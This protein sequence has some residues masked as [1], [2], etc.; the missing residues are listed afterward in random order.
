MKQVSIRTPLGIA[1]ITG[2]ENG[3]QEIKVDDSTDESS[4]TPE[5]LQTA[6]LQ[7]QEYFSGR[8]QQ[9]DLKLNPKGTDFQK[10][11]WEELR[12]IPYGTTI[13]YLELSRK[14]GDEK[15]IRAVASA[16]GKNPLWI[17]VPCH[18]VIGSDGSLTGYAGGL[19]RKK[20]LLDLENPPLQQSLF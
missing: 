5:I 7:L 6:I 10:K 2:D 8:R 3:V 16:N 9:F 12:N 11:V 4:E 19:H 17:V 13:S 15:A 14:L 18:R 1:T 20:W